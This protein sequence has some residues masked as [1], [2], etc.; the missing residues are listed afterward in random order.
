M[1][2]AAL[3]CAQ[4]VS[5]N[6]TDVHRWGTIPAV[7]AVQELH[8]ALAS[9]RKL[10]PA[11]EP[12]EPAV[13]LNSAHGVP[14]RLALKPAQSVLSLF[15]RMRLP[16]AD[17]LPK[18]KQGRAKPQHAMF[19]QNVN[20]W[21]LM[22]ALI[23]SIAAFVIKIEVSN[24]EHPARGVHQRNEVAESGD[25]NDSWQSFVHSMLC[26]FGL[27][28]AMLFW[29][30]SQ[31][32]VMSQAYANPDGS[33]EAF[34]SALTLVLVNRC[35][36]ASFTGL[37]LW[38]RGKQLFFLGF[39]HCG[40]PALSNALASWCQYESLHYVTFALQVTVKTVKLLPV[41]IVSS[42]RGKKH[43]IIDYMEIVVLVFGLVVFGMETEAGNGD[44]TATL[45]GLVLLGGL[46]CSDAFTPHLQDMMFDKH[47]ELDAMS[48]TFAQSCFAA[49]VI[50]FVELSTGMIFGSIGFVLRHPIA[51]LHMTVL[52]MSSTVTQYL[53]T[54]TIKHFGP[55]SF[56]IMTSI[57]QMIAVCIS[58]LLFHHKF[59]PV[60]IVA[61]VIVF[62]TVIIRALRPFTQKMRDVPRGELGND[63]NP[64]LPYFNQAG[65]GYLYHM[66]ANMNG[67]GPL[68]ICAIGIHVLHCFYAIAQEF[69]AAHTFQGDIFAFPMFIVAMN[70]TYASVFAFVALRAQGLH[71]FVPEMRYTAMPAL[72]NVASTFLQHSAL[73]RIY[74]PTQTLMKSLKIIPVM[75]V[76]QLLFKHRSYS[77]LDWAEGVV[78][79]GLVGFFVWNYEQLDFHSSDESS[80]LSASAAVGMVMMLGY[81]IIDAF[82]CNLQDHIYQTHNLDPSQMLLG[83][84]VISASIAW[85]FLLMTGELWAALH[86]LSVHRQAILLL[87]LVVMAVASGVGAY[88]CT[89]TVRLFGPAVFTLLVVCRQNLSLLVSASLFQHP[90]GRS[91]GLCLLVVCL[92]VL[93]STI[94]RVSVQILNQ[95]LHKP[96]RT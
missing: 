44:Y 19:L 45:T 41:V 69:L 40:P 58:G 91:T 4:L 30:V 13:D 5:L 73:Y 17:P 78:I 32:F 33:V 10:A 51:L 2:I 68:M 29:G 87:S 55:V 11:A 42:F 1:A 82:T 92:L 60:A 15:D 52:A 63:N 62:C 16:S 57:R 27:Y 95:P 31:E 90:G 9:R 3:L 93:L 59:T 46:V 77:I 61:M 81:V 34:P 85:F 65:A 12:P 64:V 36:T 24:S 22:G 86:F 23:A 20:F 6:S 7:P 35:F 21:L 14:W 39:R 75:L 76:S 49:G 25:L 28:S 18:W 38:I 94:R 88:T 89:L 53:I 72:T 43:T 83:L 70:H 47:P 96:G 50:L 79:T 80:I 56:T 66:L 48:A 8:N 67:Y 37:L 84:E 54:Y 26:V 71:A 74:F